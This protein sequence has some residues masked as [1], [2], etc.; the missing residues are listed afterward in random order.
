MTYSHLQADCLYTGISSGPNARCR[1]WEAFTFYLFTRVRRCNVMVV[2]GYFGIRHFGAAFSAV[3]MAPGTHSCVER[4][5]LIRTTTIFNDSLTDEPTILHYRLRGVWRGGRIVTICFYRATLSQ[6]TLAGP[7]SPVKTAECIAKVFHRQAAPPLLLSHITAIV[8]KIGR[9]HANSLQLLRK[10]TAVV[11]GDP[12][13]SLGYP[14]KFQ[15]V[16]RLG[17]VT[18]RHSSSGRQPN[19][20]TLN[21]GCHLYSAGRTSLWHRPTFLV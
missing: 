9:Q 3:F 8:A 17:S 19:F 13:A 18:A 16:S 15:R 21:R 2:V 5:S 11:S 6:R 14:C 12:S 7:C 20:A 4:Q 1:V 10:P